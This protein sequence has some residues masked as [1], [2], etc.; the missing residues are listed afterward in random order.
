MDGVDKHRGQQPNRDP[1]ALPM[2]PEGPRF[3]QP[4]TYSP[5]AM[6]LPPCMVL[7]LPSL[8]GNQAHAQDCWRYKLLW[9]GIPHWVMYQ[10]QIHPGTRYSTRPP[11]SYDD[12][13]CKS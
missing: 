5:E 6:S 4:Q 8:Q 3:N 10:Q 7:T 11:E 12:M 13:K 2:M 1:T 9:L